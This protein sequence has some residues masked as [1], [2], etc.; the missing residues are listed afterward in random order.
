M[1]GHDLTCQLAGVRQ[2][3]SQRHGAERAAQDTRAW[4][5]NRDAFFAHLHGEIVIKVP[6]RL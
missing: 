5:G 4:G 2:L 6:A 1:R 3:G